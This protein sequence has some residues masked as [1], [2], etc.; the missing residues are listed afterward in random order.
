MAPSTGRGERGKRL[1]LAR[2]R[3]PGAFFRVPE[4]TFGCLVL[5][6]PILQKSLFRIGEMAV[7]MLSGSWPE[8]QIG[9]KTA[10]KKS[11]A[12]FGC[13]QN[14]RRL[15]FVDIFLIF[16]GLDLGKKSSG[17][18]SCLGSGILVP[19]VRNPGAFVSRPKLLNFG[20][21]TD[22]PRV[23]NP[24]ASGQESC[25]ILALLR[26]ILAIL[27]HAFSC[28]KVFRLCRAR[29]NVAGIRHRPPELDLRGSPW[30]TAISRSD[31]NSP[32]PTESA[33]PA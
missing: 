1:P 33:Y 16:Y 5:T 25:L 23:R 28:Q 15:F 12:Y 2:V 29:R 9:P 26:F 7:L 8:L 21:E 13:R 3:N 30:G 11:Y 6:K 18:S 20:R 4:V 32:Y 14:L 22:R 17:A 27:D 24:G 10:A 31:L 19:R